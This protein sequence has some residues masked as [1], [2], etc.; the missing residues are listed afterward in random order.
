MR[1]SV[2]VGLQGAGC[3]VRDVGCRVQGAGCRVVQGAGCKVQ[4][5][6]CGVWEFSGSACMLESIIGMDSNVKVMSQNVG[7][8][9]NHSL[10]LLLW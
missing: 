9:A 5:A 1:Q 3:K 7:M 10:L 4:G 8:R 2:G 6:G